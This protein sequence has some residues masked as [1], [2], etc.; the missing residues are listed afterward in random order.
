MRSASRR[1]HGR[2]ALN[3][4]FARLW[5][6]TGVSNLA[7][8]MNVAAAPLLA[9]TLTRDPVL[10][11][12]LTVAHRLP[13][14]LLSVPAGAIADRVDRRKVLAVANAIRAA[15]VAALALSL[16]AG[17]TPLAV[18]YAAFFLV[19][20]AETLFDNA[21]FAILPSVV[22]RSDLERANGRLYA[23]TA[24]GNEFL[25]PP[26]GSFLFAALLASPFALGAAF[27][28]IS[29][30]VVLTMRGR[31]RA[32]ERPRPGSSSLPSDMKEGIGWF[33]RHALIRTFSLNAAARN[34]VHGG[35]M[36]ILVLYAQEVFGLGEAGYGILLAMASAGGIAGGLSA[37][38]LARRIS[39]GRLILSTNLVAA[40]SYAAMGA[41]TTI[42]LLGILLAF[43]SFDI[44][45]QN[46]VIVSLRQSIIPDRLLGRV[47]SAYR[48][49]AMVGMPMGAILGGYLARGWGLRSPYLLG[50]AL[51]V[52]VAFSILPI[53]NDARIRDDL[54]HA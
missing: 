51:L 15:S 46:I 16:A 33:W 18:L 24:I 5:L 13:W 31:Y 34:L 44:V 10:V 28:A 23:T 37:G 50:G 22:R 42:P 36:A 49:V 1:L 2:I 38:R 54:A 39:P 45:V 29:V 40:A 20:V 3:T 4:R 32:A 6:A 35:A 27:Y 11:A 17:A 41:T 48:M 43:V 47:T 26:I 12:G 30:L 8:G 9:A 21:S 53:V 52:L 19:G 25:G 14:L 7:D